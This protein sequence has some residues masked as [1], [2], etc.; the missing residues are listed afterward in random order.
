MWGTIHFCGTGKA[1]KDKIQAMW[2]VLLD[3]QT[4][5]QDELLQAG[6][7][8]RPDSTGYREFKKWCN[9]MELLD[10]AGKKAFCFTDKVYRYGS[11]PNSNL[12]EI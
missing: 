1:P 2:D 10:S 5:S 11:R 6:G 8:N 9:K 3:G 4:H 7:Y 12:G